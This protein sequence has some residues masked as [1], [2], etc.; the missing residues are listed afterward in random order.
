MDWST[1]VILAAVTLLDGLRRVPAGAI[2]L[3]RVLGS[4]WAVSDRETRAG[5]QLLSWWNPL[6][7]ALVVPSGGIVANSRGDVTVDTLGARLAKVQ[8]LVTVLRLLG[9]FVLLWIVFGIAGAM[10]RFDAWGLVASLGILLLLS[11][12]TAA[13]VVVVVRRRGSSW[14]EAL[15]AGAPLLYPFSAPR[16]AETVLLNAVAGTAPLMVARQLMGADRFAAWIRPHAYDAL[17]AAKL[18][19]WFD[20]RDG[21][22]S[23]LASLTAAV[24]RSDLRAIVETPPTHCA[25]GEYYCPRCARAYRSGRATCA[26]CA[27]LPLVPAA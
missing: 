16:A 22:A 10:A 21:D 14:R 18:L 25:N 26:E 19:V 24:G 11:T 3:R 1:V 2:V 5:I 12:L 4:P 9:T 6:S 8:R 15:R 27:G 13:V 7:V 23:G 20:V 17:R